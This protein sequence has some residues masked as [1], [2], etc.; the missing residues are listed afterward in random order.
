MVNKNQRITF[1]DVELA[2]RNFAGAEG[3]FNREGDRN[4][5]IFID[6]DI[7][8]MMLKDGWNIHYLKPR[9]DDEDKHEQAYLQIAVSYKGRPPRIV[10]ITSRGKT[11][12]TEDMIDTLD[13]SEIKTADLIIN[14]YEWGPINGKT[15]V[16]AYLTSLYVTI[17]E[18]ELERKY[19]DIPE[20]GRGKH[21]LGV[22]VPEEEDDGPPWDVE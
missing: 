5:C 12:L 15:G 4:F 7:A 18:D 22:E 17:I 21:R 16:K 14:P 13:W 20:T 6:D 1:Q 8:E 2:F 3:K 10:L 11:S 9:E 19:G